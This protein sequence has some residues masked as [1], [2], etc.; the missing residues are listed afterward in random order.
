MHHEYDEQCTIQRKMYSKYTVP[1]VT[2]APENKLTGGVHVH[3][4]GKSPTHSHGH[5][6][7][8]ERQKKNKL[9]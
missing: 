6:A 3:K 2:R 7:T 4:P 1:V 9:G 5:N 8:R